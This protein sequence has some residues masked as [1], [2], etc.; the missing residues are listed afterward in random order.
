MI[1]MDFEIERDFVSDQKR[2]KTP[3][4]EST[5]E[6]NKPLGVVIPKKFDIVECSDVVSKSVD[7]VS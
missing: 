4:E 6:K 3:S 2:H 7:K 5:F 1:L